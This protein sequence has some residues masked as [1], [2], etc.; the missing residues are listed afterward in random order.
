MK[1]I[2]SFILVLAILLSFSSVFVVNADSLNY[3]YG[4]LDNNGEID[5]VDMMLLERYLA[6]WDVEINLYTADVNKDGDI[7]DVDAMLL[8]RYLA[9]WEVESL[10]NTP[11][12]TKA[13][14]ITINVNDFDGV[15]EVN[16]S[17]EFDLSVSY[18][19][20]LNEPVSVEYLYF[21]TD[22]TVQV[23]DG[24]LYANH[25]GSTLVSVTAIAYF[26]DRGCSSIVTTNFGVDVVDNTSEKVAIINNNQSDYSI[27]ADTGLDDV[28]LY[29]QDKLEELTGV[30]LPITTSSTG[31]IIGISTLIDGG[32]WGKDGFVIQGSEDNILISASGEAGLKNGINYLIKYFYDAST[33]TLEVPLSFNTNEGQGLSDNRTFYVGE[34]DNLLSSYSIV[35]PD[36]V[37]DNVKY[38]A[39]ELQKYLKRAIGVELPIVSESADSNKVIELIPDASLADDGIAIKTEN[40]KIT[41]KGDE[42]RGVSYAVY[43]FLEKFIGYRFIHGDVQA[44]YR[45]VNNVIPDGI[46]YT[47]IPTFNYRCMSFYSFKGNRDIGSPEIASYSMPRKMNSHDGGAYGLQNEKMGYSLGTTWYHAHS[48]EYQIADCT[49]DTNPCLTTEANYQ[50]CLQSIRDLLDSRI[51]SGQQIGNELT[52]IS[53]AINDNEVYCKCSRCRRVNSDEGSPAG[54]LVRFLNRIVE[55]IAVEYPGME[56]FTIAYTYAKKP[57]QTVL[58]ERVILCY[59]FDGA[60]YNHAFTS[61]LCSTSG[62]QLGNQNYTSNEYFETWA[63]MTPNLYTWYYSASFYF[64]LTPLPIVEDLYSNIQYMADNG[65]IGIYAEGNGNK[66][67]TYYF[68]NLTAYMISRMEWDPY[69]SYEEYS[70]LINEYLKF[71]YGSGWEAIREYMFMWDEAS[72][73]GGK[74]FI[75]HYDWPKNMT[76]IPYYAQNYETMAQLFDEAERL[77]DNEE[78]RYKVQVLRTHMEFLALCGS[79]DS[80]YLNGNEDSRAEYTE[81]YMKLYN[82]MKENNIVIGSVTEDIYVPEEPDLERNPMYWYESVGWIPA[83][84]FYNFG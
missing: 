4:D 14:T 40:G 2:I 23:I 82:F 51:A 53:V 63:K 8:S 78:Q 33:N 32:S 12:F 56:V 47:F 30:E 18:E 7:D 77:A 45:E 48:F 19:N 81:R 10:I 24:T 59:C 52:Q 41:L 3:T 9:N 26:E 80:M 46:D 83:S 72:D 70:S 15:M 36:D 1:K 29:L 73:V 43:E 75:T 37:N 76:S 13:P 64:F 42:M 11:L 27:Y 25:I 79:H 65:T 58:D 34:A 38:A 31:K 68:E 84:D 35:R 69:M 57:T 28:S 17:V 62:G 66:N 16:E 44:L 22:N 60:C 39:T 61:G 74:C 21:T 50:E 6:M 49:W 71:Y 55:E 67:T 20:S 5:D 54:T